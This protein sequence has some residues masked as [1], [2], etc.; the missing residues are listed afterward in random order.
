M[1]LKKTKKAA[2]E[3]LM[4]AVCVIILIPF[5]YLVVNTFK[6]RGKCL[7]PR[8]LFPKAL[9]LKITSSLLII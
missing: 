8:W 3:A 6:G 7:L 2:G 9:P 5:Y 4:L 1:K